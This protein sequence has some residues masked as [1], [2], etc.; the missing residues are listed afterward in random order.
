VTVFEFLADFARAE[1]LQR[2]GYLANWTH[3]INKSRQRRGRYY[4][5]KKSS[6]ENYRFCDLMSSHMMRRTA[7]TQLLTLGVPELIVKKF[8][9]H[10]ANSKSF[11]SYVNFA[12]SYIDNNTDRAFKKLLR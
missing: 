4:E 7:I 1:K 6:S 9:G 10:S 2:I 5:C 11:Y 8:S 3:R 12:Q